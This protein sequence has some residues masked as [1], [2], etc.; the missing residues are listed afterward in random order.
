MTLQPISSEF[1]YILYKQNFVFFFVSAL[2]LSPT[3]KA[4][5]EYLKK[6]FFG[7]FYFLKIIN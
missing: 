7:D 1:P 4:L 2:S 6:K 5:V 3:I